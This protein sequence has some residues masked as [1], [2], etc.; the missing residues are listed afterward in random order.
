MIPIYVSFSYVLLLKIS[1]DLRILLGLR[2]KIGSSPSPISLR[3]E[4]CKLSLILLLQTQK[5]T[6]HILY[7][8]FCCKKKTHTDAHSEHY[9][10][11]RTADDLQCIYTLSSY[12]KKLTYIKPFKQGTGL[13]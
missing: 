3:T 8:L 7:V 9:V 12:S 2:V 1:D 4:G 11:V 6:E 10:E 5:L 13:I